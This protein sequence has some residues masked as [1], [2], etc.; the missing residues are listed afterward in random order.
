MKTRWLPSHVSQANVK[1]DLVSFEEVRWQTGA[2]FTTSRPPVPL[3]SFARRVGENSRRVFVCE[4][5]GVGG[6]KYLKSRHIAAKTSF[7]F[8]RERS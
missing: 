6:D 2:S 3:S 4:R 5:R 7:T 8:L 1:N